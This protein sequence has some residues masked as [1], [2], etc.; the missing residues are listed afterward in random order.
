MALSYTKAMK[1]QLIFSGVN[2]TLSSNRSIHSSK[3]QK[4]HNAQDIELSVSHK[5][6]H[7]TSTTN[8]PT[9]FP[10]TTPPTPITPAQPP[11]PQSSLFQIRSS[12]L[13]LFLLSSTGFYLGYY[14]SIFNIMGEKAAKNLLNIVH[15]APCVGSLNLAFTLGGAIGAILSTKL[16]DRIGKMKV[17]TYCELLLLPS[18]VLYFIPS[19]ECFIMARIISGV[20]TGASTNLVPFI[21]GELVPKGRKNFG[22]LMF[23]T[24]IIGFTIITALLGLFYRNADPLQDDQLIFN[25]QTVLG[26]PIVITLLRYLV[27]VFLYD[28][29]SPAFYLMKSRSWG[30]V[31]DKVKFMVGLMYEDDSEKGERKLQKF[32]KNFENSAKSQPSPPK[33][34]NLDQK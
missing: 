18:Y 3:S 16:A 32:Q 5:L 4:P 14:I 7:E 24:F 8:P 13:L 9:L 28:I 29:E 17:L 22:D 23:S 2:S 12:T 6:H 26:W 11:R 27:F 19:I 34:Q 20:S 30:E 1:D 21:I 25:F 33:E 31:K 10:L 15:P